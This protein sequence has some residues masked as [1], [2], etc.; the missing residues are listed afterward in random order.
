M[1]RQAF[2]LTSLQG[3]CL[4][5]SVDSSL[6]ADSLPIGMAAF[7]L[8]DMGFVGALGFSTAVAAGGWC[9]VMVQ[10]LHQQSAQLLSMCLSV[11]LQIWVQWGSP[12][13]PH[14]LEVNKWHWEQSCGLHLQAAWI[15]SCAFWYVFSSVAYLGQWLFTLI[16]GTE[17]IKTAS[18]GVLVGLSVFLPPYSRSKFYQSV[19]WKY[20]TTRLLLRRCCARGLAQRAAWCHMRAASGCSH[21]VFYSGCD[22]G[23]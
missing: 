21:G 15:Q 11:R 18:E 4:F 1:R 16:C 20:L 9:G 23:V 19:A 14:R 6:Q 3:E 8:S 10:S 7:G 5:L 13:Y 17:E 22:K 2:F 12:T